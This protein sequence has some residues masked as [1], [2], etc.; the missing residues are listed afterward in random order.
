[1][2]W[3]HVRVMRGSQKAVAEKNRIIFIIRPIILTWFNITSACVNVCAVV[4]SNSAVSD[5]HGGRRLGHASVG[6]SVAGIIIT[7]III[8]VVVAVVVSAANEATSCHDGSCYNVYY[9]R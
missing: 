6:V 5:P 3:L 4:A 2:E 7:V 9:Y 8:I 1:V